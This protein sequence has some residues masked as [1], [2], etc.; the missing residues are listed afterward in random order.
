M[1]W[2]HASAKDRFR[3]AYKTI[4]TKCEIPGHD[5]PDKDILKLVHDYLKN[6]TDRP[7]VLIIDNADDKELFFPPGADELGFPKIEGLSQYFPDCDHGSILMTTRDKKAGSDFMYGQPQVMIGELSSSEALQLI[8][9]TLGHE[10]TTEEEALAL[11][12]RMEYLPLAIAQ[13]LAYID[14]NSM[15]I[16]QYI[17]DL[18]DDNDTLV[19][20][21]SQDFQAI[22][23]DTK[24]P[25]AV[26]AAWIISFNQIK[27]RDH[28]ACE[29][30]SLM[31]M[32]DRQGIQERL[33]DVYIGG[34]KL[35][36]G[37]SEYRESK[38]A[39]LGTL[40]AY[41]FITPNTDDTYDM[42]RLVQLV[43]RKWLFM[44]R[45]MDEVA[46]RAVR[47]MRRA[48][49][50][51]DY[52]TLDEMMRLLPHTRAVLSSSMS[53]E[54]SE[55]TKYCRG[56]IKLRLGFY[57]N[58][59]SQYAEA[60]KHAEEAHRLLTESCGA[61]HKDTLHAVGTLIGIYDEQ[62][63]YAEGT[64]LA[65]EEKRRA[66]QALGKEHDVTLRMTRQLGSLRYR[67]GKL[68]E[69]EELLLFVSDALSR[70]FED[71]HRDRLRSVNDLAVV[72]R[73]QGRLDE[74]LELHTKLVETTTRLKGKDH[75]DTLSSQHNLAG[76]LSARKDYQEAGRL[77]AEI[78][79]TRKRIHGPE[80]DRTLSSLHA[81][82]R[83]H[84]DQG[85]FKQAEELGRHVWKRAKRILGQNH[86]KTLTSMEG[87]ASTLKELGQTPEAIELMRD[88]WSRRK[89]VLGVD[90][91]QT[92]LAYK[93]L[94]KWTG[95]KAEILEAPSTSVVCK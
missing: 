42:H 46:V 34:A 77:Y 6:N 79:E 89:D 4:A 9:Q 22:G 43:T 30:L 39:S 83:H 53:Q 51:V 21:L 76:I 92:I 90:H 19:K 84:F 1:F 14:K 36:D 29:F 74:A 67:E 2:V 94:C 93:L 82:A 17:Q 68:E 41:S 50:Y 87:Y 47:V 88:C 13:A 32:F 71:D 65:E 5:D 78:S 57:F 59:R 73:A 8:N 70:K 60:E 49:P 85:D 15:S 45:R 69:A 61:E 58:L 33:I 52:E 80:H 24:T 56:V 44:R 7:W 20:N 25:N 62:G 55:E 28:V 40:K 64:S 38:T 26:T 31:S 72:Y 91:R 16:G 75:P 95:D 23:R 66:E 18:G 54:A 3:Q 11:S 35:I 27:D 81:L 48:F 10:N 12:T 86:P 37:D 63:R